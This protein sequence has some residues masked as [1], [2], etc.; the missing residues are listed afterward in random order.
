MKPAAA[1]AARA[2]GSVVVLGF[3]LGFVDGSLLVVIGGLGLIVF[4]RGLLLPLAEARL[5]AVALAGFALALGVVAARWRSLEIDELRAVQAVL[6]PTLVVGTP[7]S[8]ASTVLAGI[9]A[10]SAA[11]LWASVARQDPRL[12]WAADVVLLALS[13]AS[14]LWG[15]SVGGRSLAAAANWSGAGLVAA[16]LITLIGLGATRWRY[17]RR[18]AATA[19]LGCC[20][21]AAAVLAAT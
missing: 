11:G 7:S 14:V 18:A 1:A 5:A 16:G 8:I 2:A 4:G 13:A 6:G 9:G 20:T 17:G 10:L 15:P 21:A 3:L 19:A 12:G